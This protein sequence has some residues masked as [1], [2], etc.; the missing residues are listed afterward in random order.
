MV[1]EESVLL[2]EHDSFARDVAEVVAS[3]GDG[4][5]GY[6]KDIVGNCIDGELLVSLSVDDFVESVLND[7][8]VSNRVHRR[9]LLHV[10]RTATLRASS[11]SNLASLFAL[12][13]G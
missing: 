13:E 10:F 1:D 6:S 12:A 4:Y 7:L 5:T 3:Y 11:S 2:F 8:K 9:K